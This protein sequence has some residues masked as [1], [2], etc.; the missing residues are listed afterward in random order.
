VSTNDMPDWSP[1]AL[2]YQFADALVMVARDAALVTEQLAEPATSLLAFVIAAEHAERGGDLADILLR[3]LISRMEADRPAEAILNVAPP[4]VGEPG[5]DAFALVAEL[6]QAAD[7][8]DYRG[9]AAV[10]QGAQAVVLAHLMFAEI[11]GITNPTLG[12]R[13]GV[14][15]P[16]GVTPPSGDDLHDPVPPQD[17]AE[18]QKS[19]GD[20]DVSAFSV[21]V[22]LIDG[23]RAAVAHHLDTLAHKTDYDVTFSAQHLQQV[24]GEMTAFIRMVSA[25]APVFNTELRA[26]AQQLISALGPA[27]YTDSARTAVAL[28]PAQGEFRTVPMLGKDIA[29][30]LA[31][32]A[33]MAWLHSHEGLFPAVDLARYQVVRLVADARRFAA[34]GTDREP[35]PTDRQAIALLDAVLAPP[36]G[37]SVVNRDPDQRTTAEINLIGVAKAHLLYLDHGERTPETDMLLRAGVD[38]ALSRIGLVSVSEMTD[39]ERRR[40]RRLAARG[41]RGSRKR[42]TKR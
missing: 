29:A 20:A 7:P 25:T 2:A 17:K 26:G 8:A 30:V 10:L 4:P 38:R 9:W 39:T 12:D 11:E 24:L 3:D 42:G 14:A 19:L 41:G 28:L 1:W 18:L 36:D 22:A 34:G 37:K 33:M 31:A 23:D 35:E 40:A 15:F 21:I 16:D 5:H 32:A 13:R 27:P 6:A